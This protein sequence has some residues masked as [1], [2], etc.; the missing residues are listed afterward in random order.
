MYGQAEG[1]MLAVPNAGNPGVGV[2]VMQLPD[3]QDMAVTALNYGRTDASIEVDLSALPAGSPRWVPGQMVRDIVAGQDAGAVSDTGRLA[4]SLE[5]LSGRTIV[6]PG[7]A[8]EPTPTSAPTT[9]PEPT[10]SPGSTP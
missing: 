5:A 7:Q 6:V 4:I 10:Q 2:L 3:S 9:T 1:T 8:P